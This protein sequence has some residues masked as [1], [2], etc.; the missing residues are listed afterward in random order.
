MH[1]QEFWQTEPDDKDGGLN[2]TKVEVLICLAQ[3]VNESVSA[4]SCPSLSANMYVTTGLLK[5]HFTKQCDNGS[6]D[7]GTFFI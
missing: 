7:T 4:L 6:I 3:K 1:Y 5:Y 2:L